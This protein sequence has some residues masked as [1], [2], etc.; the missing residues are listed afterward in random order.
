MLAVFAVRHAFTD[1]SNGVFQPFAALPASLLGQWL[2]SIGAVTP[3]GEYSGKG[4]PGLHGPCPGD[5]ADQ[6]LVEK[7]N[8]L[9][10]GGG[11]GR[12]VVHPAT[13]NSP[14]YERVLR[15]A[16]RFGKRVV[17]VEGLGTDGLYW[18][19]ASRDA[20]FLDTDSGRSA[21]VLVAHEL[22]HTVERDRPDTPWPSGY[23]RCCCARARAPWFCPRFET[24]R[25]HPFAG[26]D[27][28]RLLVG[29][30]CVKSRRTRVDLLHK[31]IR[32]AAGLC[33]FG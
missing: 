2:E 11:A 12:R 23:G 26:G 7:L 28:S 19:V 10:H 21:A 33:Q 17:W 4:A 25:P 31:N 3:P 24:F 5:E 1:R 30:F 15:I 20:I 16:E 27:F 22:A 9:F 14:A 29:D 32:Q 6:K 8:D 18:P 13:S